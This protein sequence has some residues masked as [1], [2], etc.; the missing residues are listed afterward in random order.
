MFTSYATCSRQLFL[1][2]YQYLA[3]MLRTASMF[4]ISNSRRAEVTEGMDHVTTHSALRLP[5]AS[6]LIDVSEFIT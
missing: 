3:A 4:N 1:S 5:C 2:E 6:G